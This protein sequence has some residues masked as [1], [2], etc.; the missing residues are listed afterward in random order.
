MLHFRSRSLLLVVAVAIPATLLMTTGCSRNKAKPEVRLART[1]ASD[2]G[3][4][5]GS[6]SG[7]ASGS[8]VAAGDAW[9]SGNAPSEGSL[10]G[11]G[12]TDFMKASNGGAG[13]SLDASGT[14]PN[15]ASTAGIENGMFSAE[16]EMIHF[17]Y[18]SSDISEQWKS[19]LDEHAAWITQKPDLM[20]QVEGHCDE[21]GTEEYNVSLGQRRADA[22]RTYLVEKGVDPNR[23]STISYGKMRPLNF[24]GTEQAMALNRRAMFLVYSADAPLASAP[25]APASTD[26]AAADTTASW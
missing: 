25:A 1:T 8:G 21:R 9:A 10:A 12:S 15:S 16:L 11:S 2:S 13:A 5:S 19:T 26:T 4:G 14:L 7:F 18:D 22:V 24:D 3:F 20:V 23:L 17:D 6:G